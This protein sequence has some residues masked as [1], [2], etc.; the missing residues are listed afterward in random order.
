MSRGITES[1][2]IVVWMYWMTHTQWAKTAVLRTFGHKMAKKHDMEVFK[3]SIEAYWRGQLRKNH[4]SKFCPKMGD[5]GQNRIFPFFGPKSFLRTQTQQ[6]TMVKTQKNL[7]CYGKMA[8]IYKNLKKSLFIFNFGSFWLIK[9]Q[10][11]AFSGTQMTL[12]VVVPWGGRVRFVSKM[13]KK[14]RYFD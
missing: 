11:K 13:M 9:C 3:G 14:F 1:A 12:K 7:C 10:K 4:K 2:A 8:E 6:R 5:W